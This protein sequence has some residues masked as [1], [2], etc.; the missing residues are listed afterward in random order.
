MSKYVCNS[1][2][3]QIYLTSSTNLGGET[4]HT[5]FNKNDTHPGSRRPTARTKKTGT[6]DKL[7]KFPE[8]G[9]DQIQI[10]DGLQKL[11]RGGTIQ[12][13]GH[14]GSRSAQGD[15]TGDTIL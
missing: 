11:H 13:P 14:Q 1:L 7:S 6:Y 8:R 2:I 12:A 15:T 9:S 10:E 4:I 3:S 5:S